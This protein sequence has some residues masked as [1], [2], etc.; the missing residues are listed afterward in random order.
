MKTTSAQVDHGIYCLH[1]LKGPFGL[2]VAHI[3]IKNYLKVNCVIICYCQNCLNS[4]IKIHIKTF[5]FPGVGNM[6]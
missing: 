2:I 3:M 4:I 5:F 6:E 1:M